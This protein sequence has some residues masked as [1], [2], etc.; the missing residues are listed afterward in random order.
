MDRFS[1]K[2]IYEW[3]IIVEQYEFIDIKENSILFSVKIVLLFGVCLY[4]D[5]IFSLTL[6]TLT[7]KVDETAWDL[8][9]EECFPRYFRHEGLVTRFVGSRG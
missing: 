7:S 9:C 6:R 2:N 3:S 4:S 8:V 1:L 5:A